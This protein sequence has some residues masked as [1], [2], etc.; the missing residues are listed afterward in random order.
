MMLIFVPLVVGNVRQESIRIAGTFFSNGGAGGTKTGTCSVCGM[1]VA[2]LLAVSSTFNGISA[3]SSAK[4]R[5]ASN[6][7]E[8]HGLIFRAD[9][10]VFEWNAGA[11]FA[12][13]NY[14][15]DSE[16]LRCF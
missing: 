13:V 1:H 7:T 9:K 15:F 6:K 10:I 2:K 14:L 8:S 3:G 16:D 5:G 12:D 11:R 4:S